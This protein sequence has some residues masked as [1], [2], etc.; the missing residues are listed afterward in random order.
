VASILAIIMHS[1]GVYHPGS[2]SPKHGYLYVTI[3]LNISVSLALYWLLIFYVAI[4]DVIHEYKPLYKLL[5]IKAILFFAFWQSV[6]IGYELFLLHF[7]FLFNILKIENITHYFL[8]FQ[9]ID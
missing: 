7:I 2:F 5:A 1:Q 6:A 9:K 3:I 4:E 8:Q